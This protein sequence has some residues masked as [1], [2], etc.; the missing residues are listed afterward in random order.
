MRLATHAV[1]RKFVSDYGLEFFPLGGDPKVLS[2]FIVKHRGVF[3]IDTKDAFAN[4]R[5]VDDVVSS[6][7]DACTQPDPEGDGEPFR[8]QVGSNPR[9]GA[10]PP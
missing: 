5:E 10:R 1:Y 4:L 3:T 7:L 8:A 2:D 6:C 9:P